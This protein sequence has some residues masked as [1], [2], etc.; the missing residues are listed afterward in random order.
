LT[1]K[2]KDEPKSD[3]DKPKGSRSLD[4]LLGRHRKLMKAL[5]PMGEAISAVRKTVEP[6][7]SIFRIQGLDKASDTFRIADK[8]R[9]SIE[10]FLQIDEATRAIRNSAVS[11]HEQALKDATA[12]LALSNPLKQT[13]D[14]LRR[15]SLA[16]VTRPIWESQVD[17]AFAFAEI[18][19]F[20]NVRDA[21]KILRMRL[22]ETSLASSLASRL[23]VLPASYGVT[24]SGVDD[25]VVSIVD[26][27][28][29]K[30][31]PLD[32]APTTL[33]ILDVIEGLTADEVFTFYDHLTQFP[34]LGL[35]HKIGQK[36][37]KAVKG[38]KAPAFTNVP[39]KLYRARYW[40]EGQPIPFSSN[41]M[42]EAPYGAAGNGRWNVTGQGLLYTSDSLD[43]AI[44]ELKG[45][46]TLPMDIIEWE[47]TQKL[48]CLDL[49]EKECPF[50]DFCQQPS[51]KVSNIDQAYLVPNF[52]AQ[53]CQMAKIDMLR[54]S[55]SAMSRVTNYLFFAPSHN[56]FHAQ[57]KQTIST[58]SG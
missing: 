20:I 47:F 57:G 13:E 25:S 14:L 19:G 9:E 33:S 2:D 56:W 36:I 21:A 8:T 34:M 27:R 54:Y 53:C 42:F 51:Y 10:P 41:Q 16:S 24:R 30:M 11:P 26:K 32:E 28:S 7:E 1:D 4:T 44:A 37:L 40:L 31:L 3:R 17:K 48:T 43:G 45:A 18:D 55:S 46:S 29:D 6:Y 15:T 23:E 38:L 22:P 50:I 35:E 58:S 12:V 52:L 5:N 49:G 39:L